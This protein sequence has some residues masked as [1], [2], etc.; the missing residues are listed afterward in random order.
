MQER[1]LCLKRMGTTTG[2]A[3]VFNR[4]GYPSGGGNLLKGN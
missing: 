4:N 2:E 1:H 3:I